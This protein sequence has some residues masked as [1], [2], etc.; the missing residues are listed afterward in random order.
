MKPTALAL[1]L[2]CGCVKNVDVKPA[3]RQVV[4]LLAATPERETHQIPDIALSLEADTDQ[5]RTPRV[6]ATG[7]SPLLSAEGADVS[8]AGDEAGT[9]GFEVDNAILLEVFTDDG[10][11]V[12]RA[13]V[14]Y[15]NGLM[16]GHENIDLLSRSSFTFDANEVSLAALLPESGRFR[17][18]AMVID[19][20]GVG[21]VSDVFLVIT[22]R[23]RGDAELRD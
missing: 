17:V 15:I 14:G 23:S 22:P 21:R 3:Q 6:V 2:L 11:R 19:T 12:G 20:G 7:E 9:Q 1:L 10:K 18:R 13:A 5:E 8:L 4:R 16:E